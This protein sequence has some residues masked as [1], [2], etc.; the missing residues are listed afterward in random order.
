MFIFYEFLTF[1]TY[2]LVVHKE[3][4]ESIKASRL[5]LGILVGSSLMLF[6]A[7]FFLFFA[8]ILTLYSGVIYTSQTF[9][10]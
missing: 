9:E 6:L 10:D 5:Y 2:P 8:L 3:T 4:D 7:N 1:A